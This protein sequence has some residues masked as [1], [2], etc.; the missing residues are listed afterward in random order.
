MLFLPTAYGV[1]GKVNVF[2]GVCLST[3]GGGGGLPLGG[4]G[5]CLWMDGGSAFGGRRGLPLERR[6]VHGRG[7]GWGGFMDEAAPASQ[8]AV[9]THPTGM[10]SC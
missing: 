2:T 8:P 4:E 9:V 3:S 7:G 10:H 6:G 1:W 5:V